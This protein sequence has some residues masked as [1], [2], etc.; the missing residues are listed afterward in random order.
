M[1]YKSKKW[2]Y[3]PPLFSLPF[4]VDMNSVSL[5]LFSSASLSSHC[6]TS[7]LITRLRLWKHRFHNATA[8]IQSSSPQLHSKILIS[9]RLSQPIFPNIVSPK[10][11]N[12]SLLPCTY[13]LAMSSVYII[14]LT[15]PLTC[16]LFTCHKSVWF[17]NHL[18]S[19]P[20]SYHVTVF[21]FCCN[22]MTLGT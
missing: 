8:L 20:S 19:L 5:Q 16:F 22:F 14:L 18:V 2:S 9:F 3:V 21:S 4:V 7:I 13:V 12:F 11:K 15:R 10:Q 17:L 1:T 6:H